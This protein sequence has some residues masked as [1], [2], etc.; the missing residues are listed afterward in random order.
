MPSAWHTPEDPRELG[1][2]RHAVPCDDCGWPFLMV[3]ED[4]H[5]DEP[6]RCDACQ[7]LARHRQEYPHGCRLGCAQCGQD[8]LGCNPDA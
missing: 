4:M 8:G 3:E 6:W 5:E 2:P 1:S 7:R